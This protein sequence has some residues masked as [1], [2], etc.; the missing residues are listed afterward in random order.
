MAGATYYQASQPLGR[1]NIRWS[2]YGRVL[3]D[4]GE[5]VILRAKP[6]GMEELASAGVH[7]LLITLEPK[8]LYPARTAS[9]IPSNISYD[10]LIHTMMEQVD[11]DTAVRYVAELSGETSTVIGGEPYTITTRWTDSGEPISKAIQYVGNHLETT[12]MDVSY[13]SWTMATWGGVILN[14][15]NVIGEIPGQT[16]P[17]DIFMISAHLDS[18]SP[19][20][21]DPAPGADDNASG[22]A[23]VLMAADIFSQFDWDCT[24][25][26]ALWTG[27]ENGIIGSQAYVQDI[28]EDGEAIAGVL[29]L[30]ML[31]WNTPGSPPDMD[32]HARETVIGSV[33]IAQIFTDVIDL[34]RLDLN[35]EII[36]DGT[37]RSDHYRFWQYQMPAILAIED[38]TGD[39]NDFNPDYHTSQDLVDNFDLIFYEDMVKAAVGS[40]A[41]LADC[42]ILPETPNY[43]Y[44]VVNTFPHDPTA[45]TQG[46]VYEEP[47]YLYE[48]TGM[49]QNSDLRKV[50]LE[51][52]IVEQKRPLNDEVGEKYFGEGV[53]TWE[54]QIIQLTWKA[55]TGFVYDKTSFAEL[56]QFSYPTQGWGLTHD[57]EHLIMSDGTSTLRFL[58]PDT[59]VEVRNVVVSDTAGPVVNLNELEY[60]QGEIFA[61]IWRTDRIARID[62]ASG[63]VV[64]WIDL[65]GLLTPDEAADA[66][67]LNGIA[68]DVDEDRL[69]VTG[70]YWP[71]LFEIELERIHDDSET[72]LPLLIYQR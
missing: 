62:P 30:D 46:L 19:P 49:W 50:K 36:P 15:R 8:P 55:N 51:S 35:P 24:L 20:A 39:A 10:P 40:F 16:R 29:N 32:L 9:L 12:G 31:A 14:N 13:H 11:V 61:N 65:S 26:F 47:N 44:R 5:Q 70:K 72:Y 23:A 60:I 41:H 4:D 38:F 17:D 66:N 68:Y 58:D 67:V 21:N 63:R 69:F 18:T 64:G 53:T 28:Y 25:R 3:Y 33:E 59:F 22:V 27:E 6:K 37:N 2:D 54:D 34:Y 56:D 48:G 1:E 42:V 57:D 43:T 7:L 52:G 71:K 45:F